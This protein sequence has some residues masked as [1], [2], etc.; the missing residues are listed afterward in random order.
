MKGDVKQGIL[1]NNAGPEVHG[2]SLSLVSGAANH[3]QQQR[4]L[5]PCL[6]FGMPSRSLIDRIINIY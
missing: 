3:D 5:Y 2:K 4:A 1:M 6:L